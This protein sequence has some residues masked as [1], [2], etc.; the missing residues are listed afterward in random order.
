MA[1][2]HPAQQLFAPPC[3]ICRTP[4][5]AGGRKAPPSLCSRCYKRQQRGLPATGTKHEAIGAVD[6]LEVYLTPA[7]R[8]AVERKAK[9]AGASTSAWARQIIEAAL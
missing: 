2:P 4:V 9:K 1:K 5:G 6:R 8:T 7:M 3:S